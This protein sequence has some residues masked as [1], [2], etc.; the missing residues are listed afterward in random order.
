MPENLTQLLRLELA[1]IDEQIREF[2]Q[3]KQAIMNLLKIYQGGRVANAAA[4]GKIL[5]MPGIVQTQMSTL[6][7]A[8]RVI[9]K[10]GP[11]KAEAIMEAI[12]QEF[13]IKPAHTLAQM[14]YVRARAKKRFYRSADGK[15][16]LLE[17]GRK[18]RVA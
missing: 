14:L 2:T 9:E 16:G 18:K 10:D 4:V 5:A 13:G 7:M 17:A 12:R 6:D 11:M 8:Q 15:F 1:R 3:R